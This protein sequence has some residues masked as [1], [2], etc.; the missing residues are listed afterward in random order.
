M[1]LFGLIKRKKGLSISFLSLHVRPLDLRRVVRAF[2]PRT[3]GV[4]TPPALSGPRRR[5]LGLFSA[6]GWH[7]WRVVALARIV[8]MDLNS[9]RSRKF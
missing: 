1:V 7:C 5:E 2:C 9:A 6:T 3:S 4:L 8:C